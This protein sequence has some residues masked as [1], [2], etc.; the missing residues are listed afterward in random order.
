MNVAA[1]EARQHQVEAGL[2]VDLAVR[3]LREKFHVSIESY[4]AVLPLCG[5]GLRIRN[6]PHQCG[7][8][9]RPSNWFSGSPATD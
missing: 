9:D 1:A 7:D 5:C 2:C 3:V 6:D 8:V 4:E